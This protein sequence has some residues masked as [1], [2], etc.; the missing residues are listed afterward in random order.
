[1]AKN[2]YSIEYLASFSKEL[3]QVLYYITFILKNKNAAEKLLENILNA[4]VKRSKN[5]EGYELYKSKI[6]IEYDWYRIYVGN[7]T[8]FYTVKNNTMKVAHLIYSARNLEYL[9]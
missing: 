1:M 3:N 8:V 5:P 6:D 2:N 7:Y 9:I 4:I